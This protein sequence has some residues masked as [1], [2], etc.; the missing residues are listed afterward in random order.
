VSGYGPPVVGVPDRIPVA[1]LN[2]TPAGSVPV[3]P[4][5]TA[6]DPAAVTVNVPEVPTVNVA[7]FALVIVGGEFTVNVKLWLALGTTSFCAVN[8]IGYVPPIVGV[9]DKTPVAALNVTPVGSAPFSPNV[10]AG[11]PVAV[12]VNVPAVPIVNVA[13]FALVIDGAE[14]TVSVKLWLA[15]GATPF[16]AVS[17]IGYVPPTVGVPDR[18]PVAALNVTPVGSVPLSLKLGAGTPIA[19]TAN[20]PAVPIENVALFALVIAGA[21]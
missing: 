20:V 19:T 15:F 8:V 10:A 11:D 5:L 3:S 13:L 1:A 4:R 21:E 6:G 17:V 16:C 7:L 2:V 9:P 12:T 14:P 18:I